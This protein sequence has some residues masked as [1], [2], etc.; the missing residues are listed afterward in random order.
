MARPAVIVAEADAGV[1]RRRTARRSRSGLRAEIRRHPRDRGSAG[2]RRRRAPLVPPRQRQDLASSRKS[3]PR[4]PPWARR[5]QD[6]LVLDGEIVALDAPGDPTGFQQLQGRIHLTGEASRP[7]GRRSPSSCSMSCAKAP[8]TCA[9]GRCTSAGRRSNASSPTT[10]T[11]VLR[12]SEQVRGDGRAMYDRALASGWEGLIAKHVDSHYNSGKRSP[13]W[14]KLKIV[15]E[16]EFVVG[17]WTEPR[18]SRAYFGALLLGVYEERHDDQRGARRVRRAR[19]QDDKNSQIEPSAG[20]AA[21]AFPRLIYVGH[22][23]TGFDHRELGRL[24][25]LL[26]PLETRRARSMPQPH[27]NERRALGEARP[28][29]ADQ[30]HRVDGGQQVAASCLP[31]LARRQEAGRRA[32]RAKGAPHHAAR[33]CGSTGSRADPDPAPKARN[34]R[35]AHRPGA[36][37]RREGRSETTI[38]AAETVD[39]GNLVEQLHAIEDARRDGVLELPDGDRFAGHQPAQAVLAGARSSPRATCFAT[40]SASRRSCC[41]PSPIGRW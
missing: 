12:I 40:T 25:K 32:A 28:G 37:S 16:Q 17:G 23:G 7:A 31:G 39:T 6:P 9:S 11:P 3:P 1:A 20:S 10:R 13:D 26:K 14:R 15:Q 5:R 29:R 24:M 41:R 30:V 18:Q 38:R 2:R 33:H 27:T 8:T 22:T 19:N 35:P 34:T 36:Q 4:S 21:S